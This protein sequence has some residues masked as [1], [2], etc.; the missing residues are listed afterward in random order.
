M[1]KEF[2]EDKLERL[3]EKHEQC[4]NMNFDQDKLKFYIN[5]VFF[6]L[7]CAAAAL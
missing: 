5:I 4:V 3:E 7:T 1:C 6:F 2:W